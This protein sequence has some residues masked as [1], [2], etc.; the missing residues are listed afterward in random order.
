MEDA[1][2]NR[3]A[4]VGVAIYAPGHLPAGYG[5]LVMCGHNTLIVEFNPDEPD[6]VAVLELAF[7]AAKVLAGVLG[8]KI[9]P[10]SRANKA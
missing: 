7:A 10:F 5:P 8:S 9:S 2:I 4:V 6:D 1:R 3:G